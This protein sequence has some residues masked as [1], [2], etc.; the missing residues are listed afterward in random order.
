MGT[1]ECFPQPFFPFLKKI[2]L[3]LFIYF[4]TESLYVGLATLEK[5]VSFIFYFLFYMYNC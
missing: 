5:Y 1:R 4:E 2:Y 3:F